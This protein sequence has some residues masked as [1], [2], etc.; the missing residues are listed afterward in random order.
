M[1]GM[2]LACCGDIQVG[3]RDMRVADKSIEVLEA[4]LRKAE[5]VGSYEDA[6]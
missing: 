3:R 4:H 1:E 2:R 5:A 6:A